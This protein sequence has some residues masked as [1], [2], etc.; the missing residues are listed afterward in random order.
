[1][2]HEA[3][4]VVDWECPDFLLL[5]K[6]SEP[7]PFSQSISLPFPLPQSAVPSLLSIPFTQ[8][9]GILLRIFFLTLNAN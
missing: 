2:I 5:N 4:E 9:E 7:S 8:F 6:I 3:L 1:M